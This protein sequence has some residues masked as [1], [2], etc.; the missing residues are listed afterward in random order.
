MMNTKFIILVATTLI[1]TSCGTTIR[2]NDTNNLTHKTM[3][4]FN[5]LEFKNKNIKASEVYSEIKNDTVIEI[6]ELND[7]YLKNT[8]I[9]NSSYI[10]KKT[11]YKDNYQLKAEVNYFHMFP[12]GISKKYDPD[13]KVIET[14]N[15]DEKYTF[16]V[17]EL[18]DK[19]K[20]DFGFD[21]TK[22]SNIG[23]DR[24]FDNNIYIYRIIIP[25]IDLISRV[26]EI[27]VDGSSGN[28]ISDAIINLQKH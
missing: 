22:V 26:R 11:Y 24:Y 2:K 13:G 23:V 7:I 27:K 4:K 8:R 6:G 19:M 20:N 28:I 12:I 25:Q 3:E 21:L 5:I 9:L 18:I 17:T 1:I 15:W 14:K 16:S 10:N